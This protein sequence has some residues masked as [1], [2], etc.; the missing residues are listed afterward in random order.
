MRTPDRHATIGEHGQCT[1]TFSACAVPS[2][3]TSR[4]GTMTHVSTPS[5]QI[6]IRHTM[7]RPCRGRVASVS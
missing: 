2:H 5:R 1:D 3:M 4:V 7:S 6:V